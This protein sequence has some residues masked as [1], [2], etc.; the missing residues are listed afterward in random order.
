MKGERGAVD[1]LEEAVS[2]LR[3]AS[4]ATIVTYLVGAIPLAIGMLFFVTDMA[5]D[6][7]AAERLPLDSLAVAILLVW[8]SV[9]EALFEARLYSQLAG[10]QVRT[11]R[12]GRLILMQAAVQP[13]SLIVIPV[14]LLIMLPFPWA[15][16][17]F[18]NVGLFVALGEPDPLAAAKQQAALWTRQH[19]AQLS[20]ISLSALLLFANILIMILLLPQ[21]GRS[22]LGIEGDFARIGI[23]LLNPTTVAVA[24]S[25]TWLLIDAV[26]SA[27]YVLR[28]FHGV[29][30]ETGEDLRIAL[31]RAGGALGL[32]ALLAAFCLPARAQSVPPD[33][34]DPAIHAIDS[35]Q[36]HRSIDEVIRRRE[37]AWRVSRSAAPEAE[38]RWQSWVR[39][40][41]DGIGRAVNWIVEKI[42]EWIPANP[43]PERDPSTPRPNLEIWLAAGALALLLA[44]TALYLRRGRAPAAVIAKA[45]AVAAAV[46]VADESVTADQMAEDSWLMLARKLVEE[47]DC[48]LA[49]RALY[50]GGLSFL[51]QRE[52]IIISRWKT[53]SEYRRELERRAQRKTAID[54]N[55]GPAFVRSVALFER[56][57]YGRQAVEPAD[58]EALALGLEEVRR[59]AGG[60]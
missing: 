55:M 15:I 59:Y 35:G 33:V 27:L 54:A 16:A 1:V 43:S 20:M 49:L 6:A 25:L 29:S 41:L 30:I 28:C 7:F 56:G 5:R 46:N 39:S 14:S 21:L 50:L 11:A 60:A 32:L 23:G 19:W 26:L 38:G 17:F 4:A 36:L 3:A 12:I 37:F 24:L 34:P 45:S 42:R 2:L 31:K 58:V 13:L 51:A 57:W 8:K 22:F 9:W 53:G 10:G 48:R 40:A 52:L 18:R 44:G 47:G